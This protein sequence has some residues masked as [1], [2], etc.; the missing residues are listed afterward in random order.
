VD[1]EER[2]AGG[3]GRAG[4]PLHRGRDVVE[5]EIQEDRPAQRRGR[6]HHRRPLGD[7]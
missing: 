6:P 2:R 3:G 1:G 4:R 7:V 5:L